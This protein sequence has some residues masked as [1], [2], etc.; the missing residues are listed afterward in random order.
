MELYKTLVKTASVAWGMYPAHSMK[1]VIGITADHHKKRH[2]VATA[3][4]EAV[5][6]A[7]GLPILLPPIQGMEFHYLTLCDGFIFSGGDDPTMEEWGVKTHPNA[8]PVSPERQTFEVSLLTALQDRKEVPV[9]GVCL[10]MQWM[11]LLAGGMLEQDLPEPLVAN[12][13]EADHLVSGS[14]GEGVVHSRHHQ[15]LTSSGSLEIVAVSE[16]GVI[17]AVKSVKHFWYTGVQWHPERTED[18]KL[19]QDLFVQLVHAS[20]QQKVPLA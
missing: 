3:Y 2:R 1:P 19:G 18:Q 16:D 15:A 12:H 20:T 14:I 10:G 9:L 13:K 8:T 4:S 7:G 17:E 11:G 5:Q 6:K